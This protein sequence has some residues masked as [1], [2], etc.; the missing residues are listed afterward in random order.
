MPDGSK[1]GVAKEGEEENLG[2]RARAH[3]RPSDPSV[4]ATGRPLGRMSPTE[5]S[6]TFDALPNLDA[7]FRQHIGQNGDFLL[8]NRFQVVFSAI[9]FDSPQAGAFDPG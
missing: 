8:E 1:D 6:S 5:C 7:Q 2:N 4:N 3:C 9:G